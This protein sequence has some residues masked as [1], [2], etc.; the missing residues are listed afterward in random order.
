MIQRLIEKI[1]SFGH[2]Y[3]ITPPAVKDHGLYQKAGPLKQ[4]L[5]PGYEPYYYA[6]EDTLERETSGF[7]LIIK[8]E[9][10]WIP[11]DCESLMHS[12]AKFIVRS[13]EAVEY[14]EHCRSYHMETL[15]CGE[16][17]CKRAGKYSATI[18]FKT[19]QED[20]D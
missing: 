18:E 17:E 5:Y 15:I 19:G 3:G 8:G 14:F 20:Y 9:Y 1:M 10:T 6:I 4:L 12:I 13:D 16:I 11:A 7:M 2:R